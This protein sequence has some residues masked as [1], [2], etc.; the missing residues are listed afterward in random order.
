VVAAEEVIHD[1]LPGR[2]FALAAGSLFFELKTL[3]T[4]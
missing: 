4:G 1:F 3:L 2:D